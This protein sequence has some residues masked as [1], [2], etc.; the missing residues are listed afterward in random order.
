LAT[1]RWGRRQVRI[2]KQ[3]HICFQWF[4]QH[5][6]KDWGDDQ[7]ISKVGNAPSTSL[8]ITEMGVT[9]SAMPT[10]KELALSSRRA[11][12][13]SQKHTAWVG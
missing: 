9:V 10:Q 13:A 1:P 5:E 6:R 3:G 7:W 4:Y 8:T 12:G 2:W 11:C